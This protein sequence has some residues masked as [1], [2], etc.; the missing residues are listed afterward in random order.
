MRKWQSAW[1][2]KPLLIVDLGP[3]LNAAMDELLIR[4][5]TGKVAFRDI[6]PLVTASGSPIGRLRDL[7]HGAPPV[8]V[9]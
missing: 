1:R 6:R 9:W 7:R 8:T 4:T 2:R 3:A 5:V